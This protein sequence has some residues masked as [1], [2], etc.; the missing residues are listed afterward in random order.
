MATDDLAGARAD[1]A[2][3]CNASNAEVSPQRLL[4]MGALAEVDFRLGSWDASLAAAEHALSLAQDTEQV[5][6]QG[7][8]HSA[9]VLVCAGRGDWARADDHLAAARNLAEQLGDLATFAVCENA[10]V[11]IAWCRSDPAEVVARSA[12]LHSLGGG[13]THEP[14]LTQWPIQ[15]VS[16]L[17][18][19]GRLDEAEPEIEEFEAL[20]RDRGCQSRLAGLARVRGELATARRDHKVA[21]ASFEAALELDHGAVSALDAALGQAAFGRFLRRRG[22][23]RAAVTRLED[24]KSRLS[25]LGA[26]PFAARVDEE[27]A[28]CGVTPRRRTV[29]LPQQLT[30]QERTIATLVC[31]GLTNQEVAQQLVLSVKTVSYHLGNVYAKLGVHSRT[32][33]A[34]VWSAGS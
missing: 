29:E 3:V 25:A 16:A 6:V 17:V 9:A 34:A 2:T 4:A 21:R 27:L 11:H 24:A 5:W 13:P 26:R 10:G 8:L 7:F 15:Y 19:L 1:L 30:P 20:A 28:A 22:E 31:Q 23:K 32:R 33:L 14:G 18:E 12:F